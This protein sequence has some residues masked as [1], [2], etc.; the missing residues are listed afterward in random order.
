[1]V[2]FALLLTEVT[3][4]TASA[5]LLIPLFLGLAPHIDSVPL[6]VLVAVGTS[7]AF[8]LPVATPPNAIV[9]GTGKVPQREMIRCGL[10]VTVLVYPVLVLAAALALMLH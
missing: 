9:F 2:L 4:N 5:A 6:A 10:W 7:C 3:S 1:M 8:M